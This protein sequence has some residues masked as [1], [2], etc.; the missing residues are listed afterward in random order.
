MLKL[1]TGLP[2]AGKT[3]N[4][5]W[6]FLYAPE[7]SGRPK[8]CTPINGFEPQ[9][10]GV[11][12]IEH[13]SCWQDLPEGS[14]IFCDEVQDYIGTDLGKVEPEWVKQLARHRHSGKDFILTTQSPMFLHTFVRKLVQPHVNYSKP[15]G[16]TY[17]ADQWETVQNDPT[18]RANKAIAQRSKVKPN[19]GVFKLYTSTVLDTHKARPPL[20][21]LIILSL[22]IL[23]SVLC[24]VFG[25][26]RILHMGKNTETPTVPVQDS[27]VHELAQDKSIFKPEPVLQTAP[28]KPVW[29]AENMQPRIA[30][31][32]YTAPIY[33]Q[34]TT[35]TDFPRV[36]GCISSKDPERCKCYSQQATPL[37]VPASACEVF[38]KVGSFDPWLSG[39]RQQQQQL[40]QSK[41]QAQSVSPDRAAKTL[42][43][44][45]TDSRGDKRLQP[46]VADAGG[47]A[48][49]T[50]SYPQRVSTVN[51]S[52]L[53]QVNP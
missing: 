36:A 51:G 45:L 6:S 52:K 18:S 30:G 38:V 16:M 41:Q 31:Q 21:K 2:G 33:D 37:D 43:A 8:Y 9:E 13:I 12:P 4:E 29:T 49:S 22:C 23:L 24:V 3:S 34:L 35:P 14:V 26:Y 46:Q 7:Y 28:T 19:P 27:A 11:T 20:K 40:A 1:A 42:S 15:F 47:F 48:A 10:H 17:Y 25:L 53:A 50:S 44:V 5:L 32:A 39:R